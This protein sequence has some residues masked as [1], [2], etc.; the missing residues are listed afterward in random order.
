LRVVGTASCLVAMCSTT[1]RVNLLSSNLTGSP[2]LVDISVFE[3]SKLKDDN[4]RSHGKERL[5]KLRFDWTNMTLSSPMAKRIEAIMSNCS[6]PLGNTEM[7]NR[8][9]LELKYIYGRKSY[10]TPWTR[11]GA[12]EPHR[13]GSGSTKQFVVRQNMP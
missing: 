2:S 9:G 8:N 7:W 5:G 12:Y 6:L 13:L 1:K 11:T 4:G 3:E 10:A